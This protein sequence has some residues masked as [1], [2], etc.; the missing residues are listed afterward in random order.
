AKVA[1][2]D[3]LLVASG[4]DDRDLSLP[5]M[6]SRRPFSG[7]REYHTADALFT[8][9][10][11]T[12]HSGAGLF[13]AEGELVGVGSLLVGNAAGTGSPSIRGSTVVSIAV[14]TPLLPAPRANG[15]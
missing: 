10:A 15:S 6:G 12:D 14:L 8:A 9:P 5:R 3:P 11:R 4:G 7:F 2:D 13:T 1:G